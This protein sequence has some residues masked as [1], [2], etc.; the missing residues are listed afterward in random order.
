MVGSAI[1]SS[2][3]TA[4]LTFSRESSAG[5][6]LPWLSDNQETWVLVDTPN[7]GCGFAQVPSL[8]KSW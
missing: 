4:Q 8:L 7:L 2:E 3:C 1:R 5:L 6:D